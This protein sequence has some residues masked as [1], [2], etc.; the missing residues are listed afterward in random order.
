[1]SNFFDI[2]AKT[3]V[4]MI[5][6]LTL[7]YTVVNVFAVAGENP[8]STNSPGDMTYVDVPGQWTTFEDLTPEQQQGIIAQN[9]GE[10]YGFILG[11]VGVIV[12]TVLAIVLAPVGVPLLV[13]GLIGAGVGGL[14]GA[15]VG[16]TVGTLTSL[17][18]IELPF[19]DVLSAMKDSLGR[20]FDFFLY[21][22]VL[23]DV[24]FSSPNIILHITLWF[25]TL[26]VLAVVFIWM[27]GIG[28]EIGKWVADVFNI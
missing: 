28:V 12:G 4:I 17:A 8:L 19:T 24:G 10:S 14:V 7:L 18:G 15:G 5:V 21:M 25:M 3:L 9:Q 26:P 23:G 1:M 27:L 22:N 13:M 6:Y 2:K 11:V 16:Y 20:V